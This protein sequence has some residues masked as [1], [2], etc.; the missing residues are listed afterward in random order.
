MQFLCKFLDGLLIQPVQVGFVLGV[1]ALLFASLIGHTQKFLIFVVVLRQLV[2]R[3]IPLVYRIGI[4]L[5]QSI[6]GRQRQF[7]SAKFR[8]I[9]TTFKHILPKMKLNNIVVG[10]YFLL[11]VRVLDF[12]GLEAL[13][14]ERFIT[15][16]VF[17]SVAQLPFGKPDLLTFGHEVVKLISL[18][19][20]NDI[21]YVQVGANCQIVVETHL[22]QQLQLLLFLHCVVVD[23]LVGCRRFFLVL[24]Y[25]ANLDQFA[26]HLIGSRPSE[27]RSYQ[28]QY[29]ASVKG[30]EIF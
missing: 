25:F 15:N 26:H 16:V 7:L 11:M 6:V 5:E 1:V 20:I 12:V 22:I 14:L 17:S 13:V 4:V 9:D 27:S 2:L 10:N 29:R 28:E 30:E 23:D 21:L 24:S 8:N 18:A 19:Q 3:A